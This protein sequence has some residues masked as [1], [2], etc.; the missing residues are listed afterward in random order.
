MEEQGTTQRAVGDEEHEHSHPPLVHAHDH[1]HVSHHHTGGLLGEFE[2]RSQYHVH[3][4]NHALTVHAHKNLSENDELRDHEEA[5][6]V[7]DH[8]APV[9]IGH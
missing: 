3:E 7:H 6:H 8:D 9:G 4:H 1:W 2:H 5:A